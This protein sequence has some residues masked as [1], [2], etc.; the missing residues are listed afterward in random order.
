MSTEFSFR[1]RAE[2]IENLKRQPLDVLVIGGGIVGAGLIR[3]LA[4]NGG[5]RA[6]LIEQ[7][8]FASGT[9]NATS[10]L[11][12]GGFR[13][14]LKRDVALVKEARRE[15]EILLRIA[16]NIVKPLPIVILCYK[17]ERYPL[18]GMHLAAHYYNHLSK[19]DRKEKAYALRDSRKI[20]RLV[21]P[22]ETEGLIGCVVIWDST[23]DDA[24]LTL[25]TIRS[26]HHYGAIV[27]N[28]VRL[29]D[30]LVTSV[31]G[32]HK[33]N[34]VLAEDVMSGDRFEIHAKKIVVA[35]GPWTDRVWSKDP[36]YDGEPKLTTQKAKGT[37]LLFPQIGN[38]Q[39]GVLA[40]THTE[41]QQRREPRVLFI[42]P[43]EHA[44]SMVGTTESDPEDFPNRVRPSADEIEYLLAE[45]SR[46]FPRAQMS[47]SNIISAYAGV[48]PLVAMQGDGFVSRAHKV[49]ESQS[50]VMY[51]YG[52]KLTTYRKIGE[53]VV[54]RVSEELQLPRNCQTETLKLVADEP[55]RFESRLLAKVDQQRLN[56]R[57]GFGT[58]HIEKL[59]QQDAT[60]A[61]RLVESLPFLKAEVLY[62]CH[63]EMVIKLEDFLWRRTRIG[64]TK[65]QGISQAPDIARLIGQ[66]CGWDISRTNAE[67][68]QYIQR[69]QWLNAEI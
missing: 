22:V 66:V 68:E 41:T 54:N 57:Y 52:G 42:L 6:G 35:I 19:A 20:Q 62:A 14:L 67:I 16:P 44:L 24:R 60:L 51:T 49:F 45:A 15:R 39:Y 33:I 43:A 50:G 58:A 37:H 12:H 26:A 7:Q 2:N 38:S 18:F 9:S 5:I 59:I 29:L 10:E 23:V 8:D 21:G 31:G 1:T 53:E 17:G 4:L 61:D 27:T 25:L 32:R 36:T 65:G 55:K 63:E 48:R 3:D 30:F 69:I 13:Y 56:E 34:G 28:Y 47:R 40:F 46:V 64:L 11:V